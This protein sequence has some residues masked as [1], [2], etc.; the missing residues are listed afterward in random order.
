MRAFSTS[1]G[2]REYG[3]G[4]LTCLRGF[5]WVLVLVLCTGLAAPLFVPAPAAAVEQVTTHRHTGLTDGHSHARSPDTNSHHGEQD[6]AER[7]FGHHGIALP[8][9]V[10]LTHPA[11]LR[12]RFGQA[13]S[14]QLLGRSPDQTIDPPRR[15]T[16]R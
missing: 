10:E 11:L 1:G 7:I 12:V 6:L 16:L 8:E 4:V 15:L 14:S 2:R 13:T 9:T 5:A 3:S